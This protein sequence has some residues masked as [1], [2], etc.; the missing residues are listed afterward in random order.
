[1]SYHEASVLFAF[2]LAFVLW[3]FLSPG[4]MTGWGDKL[5]STTAAG[6]MAT[7]VDDATPA[8]L[9][10]VLLFAL[11]AKPT[12]LNA[13]GSRRNKA[14]RLTEAWTSHV[15]THCLVLSIGKN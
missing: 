12:F 8:V 2:V 6:G 4:F 5:E 3:F 10:A 11:P 1:M 9:V 15:I 14:R 13:F 7:S